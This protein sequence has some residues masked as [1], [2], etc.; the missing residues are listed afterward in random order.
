MTGPVK[1]IPA[2]EI[3]PQEI[4]SVSSTASPVKSAEITMT[5]I[6]ADGTVE[7][8]GAVSYYHRNP[9]RRLHHRLFVKPKVEQA[10]KDA[11]SRVAVEEN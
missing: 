8:I 2:R 9:L 10:I 1:V 4:S 6:R 7:E 11:N 5:I 3:P